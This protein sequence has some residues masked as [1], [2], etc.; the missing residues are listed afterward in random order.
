L[1]HACGLYI[2]QEALKQHPEILGKL[3]INMGK[4]NKPKLFRWKKIAFLM[5]QDVCLRKEQPTA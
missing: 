5:V 4:N 3:V 2:A 1:L